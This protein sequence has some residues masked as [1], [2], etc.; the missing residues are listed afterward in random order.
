MSTVT[1]FQF[2]TPFKVRFVETDLQGHVFFGNYLVYFDEALME[3]F[4]LLGFRW[5]DMR[6]KGYDLVYVESRV[7]YKGSAKFEDILNTHVRIGRIGNSSV[8]A[9]FQ[10]F[11]Q[12]DNALIALGELSLVALDLV[13]RKPV[14]VPDVFREAVAKYQDEEARKQGSE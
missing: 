4:N 7:Q 5:D 14:R 13:T 6:A 1:S 2:H 8:T 3:Y 10:I 9:E 11:R 12:S